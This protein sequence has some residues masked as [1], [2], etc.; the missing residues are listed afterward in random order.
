MMIVHPRVHERH[1]NLSEGDVRSAWRSQFRSVSRDTDTGA[2]HVAVGYDSKGREVEMVAI[3]L[4]NGDW[5][6][7][8][9]MTPP[10]AKTYSELGLG[11]RG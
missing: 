3:G 10:S 11:R 1:P 9:A 8:H 7:Y 4:E 2:R 6:V 5:L